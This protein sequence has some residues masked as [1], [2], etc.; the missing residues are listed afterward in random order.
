MCALRWL[1]SDLKHN[2]YGGKGSGIGSNRYIYVLSNRL[3]VPEATEASRLPGLQSHPSPNWQESPRSLHSRPHTTQ[4][5]PVVSLR[6]GSRPRTHTTGHT[7]L[8]RTRPK[9][10]LF[11]NRKFNG[12]SL[13]SFFITSS[14]KWLSLVPSL[15]PSSLLFYQE[16]WFYIY[17]CIDFFSVWDEASFM[18]MYHICL[19]I[20][21]LPAVLWPQCVVT[22]VLRPELGR[23]WHP[24]RGLPPE[25]PLALAQPTY[26]HS[27]GTTQHRRTVKTVLGSCTCN[28]SHIIGWLK[29]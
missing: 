12:F 4:P 19:Q 16:S 15:F 20:P 25:A 1:P 18:Y 13:I 21:H 22:C 9:S 14:F 17:L 28:S 5:V 10:Q 23:W 7:T 27:R 26:Y 6:V 3:P 29:I 24:W 11:K 8:S 2:P